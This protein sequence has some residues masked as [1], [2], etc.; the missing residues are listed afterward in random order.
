MSKQPKALVIED[1]PLISRLIEK[2]LEMEGFRI[3]KAWN[4]VEG[5][6]QADEGDFDL[7]I[8]DFHLPDIDGTEV[9]QRL[10]N[11]PRAMNT[12]IIL[13][14]A[15]IKMPFDPSKMGDRKIAFIEK[16]FERSDLVQKVRA[17]TGHRD[18][19]SSDPNLQ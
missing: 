15:H 11:A 13:T 6:S 7:I 4:G 5:C 1:D 12:P 3:E 18:S 2:I 17:I 8:L 9:L 16:P 14:T 10:N 19:C